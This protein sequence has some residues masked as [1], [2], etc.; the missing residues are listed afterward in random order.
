[1]NQLRTL[2]VACMSALV[3]IAAATSSPSV[4]A[5]Q[6]TRLVVI[7][8]KGSAVAGLSHNELKRLFLGST[9]SG[10]SGSN[11]IGVNQAQDAPDRIG[12]G[13]AVLGMSPDELG[14]Y[15]ID[16]KIR[17]QSGPPKSLGSPEQVRKAV[18]HNPD[19]VGYLRASDLGPDVKAIPI[20]G[21]DAKSPGYAVEY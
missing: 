14:R 11:L 12:F 17:G 20:D 5:G 7:V 3:V 19:A 13:R 16:R 9:V 18:G 4:E 8:A 10:P 2:K 6:K 21:K 15:W 1:M